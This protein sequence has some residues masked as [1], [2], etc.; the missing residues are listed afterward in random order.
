M[1]G[2]EGQKGESVFRRDREM[3]RNVESGGR[4]C[5]RGG[6]E[7]GKNGRRD[8]GLVATSGFLQ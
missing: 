8:S 3:R 7:D 2:K 1:S 5:E 4:E 6:W